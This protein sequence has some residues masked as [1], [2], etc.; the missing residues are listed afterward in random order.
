MLKQE[1]TPAERYFIAKLTGEGDLEIL[2]QAAKA[3]CKV[4]PEDKTDPNNYFSQCISK[5]FIGKSGAIPLIDPNKLIVIYDR[6]AITYVKEK[7]RLDAPE[8][9]PT[10]RPR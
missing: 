8:T 3:Y 9:A 4:H 10:Q 2:E 1:P 6:L 5:E 7:F